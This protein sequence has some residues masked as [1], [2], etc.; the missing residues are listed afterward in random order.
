MGI[1]ISE[2]P[3]RMRRQAEKKLSEQKKEMTLKCKSDFLILGKEDVRCD[4]EGAE[5]EAFFSWVRLHEGMY[6]CLRLMHHIPNGGMRNEHEAAKLKRQGVKKGVPDIFLPYASGGYH[7]LYIELKAKGGALSREQ[8]EFL[9]GA[10]R[11]GY[12][13][14][15]CFG[16]DSAI[17][18]AEEYIKGTADRISRGEPKR[19]RW[20]ICSDGY[21]PYCSL[22]LREPED[23]KRGAVCPSC[24]AVMEREAANWKLG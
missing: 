6:P 7:G 21:Y 15:A 9:Q 12:F 23:G 10:L 13:A 17:R 1:D 11:V 19:G 22:C 18:V 16:A 5:Q 2:L 4:D 3:E 24:G 8:K 20:I 14:V